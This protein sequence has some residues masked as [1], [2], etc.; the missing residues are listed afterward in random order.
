MSSNSM[1]TTYLGLNFKDLEGFNEA[2]IAKQ[3]WG[4]LQNENLCLQSP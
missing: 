4:I 3:V 1:M 2:L